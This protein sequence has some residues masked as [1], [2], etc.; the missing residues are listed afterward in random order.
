M[1]AALAFAKRSSGNAQTNIVVPVC[2]IVPVAIRG[3]AVILIIVPGPAAQHSVEA[4][5]EANVTFFRIPFFSKKFF[6]AYA[7]RKEKNKKCRG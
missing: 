2:S 4:V 7:E 1:L 5:S 3:P 6:S